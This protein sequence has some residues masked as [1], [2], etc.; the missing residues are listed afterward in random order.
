MPIVNGVELC[1]DFQNGRCTKGPACRFAHGLNDPRRFQTGS[2]V[3]KH[4]AERRLREGITAHRTGLPKALLDMFKPRPEPEHKGPLKPRAYKIHFTPISQ[5]VALFAEPGDAEYEPPRPDTV[6]EGERALRN[7]EYQH[8][9]RLDVETQQEKEDRIQQAKE[10]AAKKALEDGIAGWDPSKNEKLDGDPFKTLFVGR[11]SY[12]ATEKK[13]RREFEEFG[14]VKS[15]VLVEDQ[16][17][18]P[19]GYAFVEFE[20]KNDMKSAYKMA[21]GRKIEGRRI[22]VDVERGRTVPNWRPRRLGGGLGGDSRRL[23]KKGEKPGVAAPV[24]PTYD[25]GPPPPSVRGG[26]RYSGP[27]SRGGYDEPP[28]P[29]MGTAGPPPPYRGGDRDRGYSRDRESRREREGR[30]RDRSERSRDRDGRRERDREEK[31][32]DR[33]RER[34]ARS[35]DRDRDRDGSRRERDRD[36]S[37]RERDRERDVKRPREEGELEEGE[38]GDKRRRD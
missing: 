4:E 1:G 32:R 36:S 9:A 37:R 35:R 14:P 25:A 11:L 26:D 28:P 30:S 24:R 7:P 19:C 12:E 17:G 8:Q 29:Y 22:V 33:D 38:R 3:S 31:S 10:E 2:T 16:E 20:H 6:P 18:K 23:R 34:S 5:Y 15:V 13:L 27:P 21:D